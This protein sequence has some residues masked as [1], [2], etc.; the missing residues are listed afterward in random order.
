MY[1]F[2]GF[3]FP[4]LRAVHVHPIAFRHEF[5]LVFVRQKFQVGERSF[6]STFPIIIA[7]FVLQDSAEPTAHRRSPTKAIICSHCREE[8]LLNQ[9]L[10]DVGLTYSFEGI[11]VENVTVFIDPAFGIGR[12]GSGYPTLDGGLGHPASSTTCLK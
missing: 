11:A 8:C 3:R 7:D 10:R 4:F 1:Y 9:V 2:I 6:A 12:S 5:L